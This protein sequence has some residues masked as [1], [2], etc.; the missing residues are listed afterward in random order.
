[1][2]LSV[3]ICYNLLCALNCN[4]YSQNLGQMINNQSFNF[5]RKFSFYHNTPKY[6]NKIFVLLNILIFN[7]SP[8]LYHLVIAQLSRKHSSL[9][10]TNKKKSS[11]EK[12]EKLF[13]RRNVF[14]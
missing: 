2:K 12:S 7:D 6:F 14:F 9:S 4:D 10:T 1:M 3:V 13:Y 5:N 8:S 11:R